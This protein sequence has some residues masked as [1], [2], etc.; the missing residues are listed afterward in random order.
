MSEQATE[1]F[2][3]GFV[4]DGGGGGEPDFS[5]MTDQE[6]FG[7]IFGDEAIFD[8][9]GAYVGDAIDNS[10]EYTD[11]QFASGVTEEAAVQTAH[12]IFDGM[13][14]LG[15]FDR[16]AAWQV[17]DELYTANAHLIPPGPQAAAAILRYSA[18][19][20]A[21][22]EHAQA[23]EGIAST[24]LGHYASDLGKFD[25]QAARALADQI[26]NER[27]AEHGDNGAHAA[28]YALRVASE[29]TAGQGKGDEHSIAQ[30][31]NAV[32]SALARA[33][34][35]YARTGQGVK[36]GAKFRDELDFAQAWGA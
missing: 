12:Q 5:S 32:D 35:Q 4:P 20:V 2:D 18:E 24:M 6:V 33:E 19:M 14:D 29:R 10:S 36:R 11:P 26:Y 34:T 9:H 27:V 7:D 3:P 30:R 15:D 21:G 8:E 1:H 31:H 25:T 28:A 13:Q 22:Y 17:A 16:N 23:G